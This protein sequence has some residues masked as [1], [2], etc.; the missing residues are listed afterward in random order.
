M[1]EDAGSARPA[2]TRK[3][4]AIMFTDIVGFS[5]Q[6]GADEARMLRLLDLHNQI[7]Q[8]AVTEH[9][10][11]VIKTV[12]DAFLVD[13]P[14]VVH[15]VQC[16][17]HIQAQFRT[18]NADKEPNEQIHVRIGIHLGDIVQRDG[19]VFGDGVNVA[20][21]LQELA[22]P[23]SVCISHMV[24]REVEKK[25]ALGTV[26]SLGRPKLKNI[27]QREPVYALL[28]EKPTGLRQALRVQQFKLSRRVGTAHLARAVLVIV[29]LLIGGGIVTLLYPSLPTF[30]TRPSSLVPQEAPPALPLPDKPSIVVLPFVNLSGDPGQ[31]YFSDGMTEDLITDLS[32]LS[33]LFVIARNSAFTY[34]GKA[35][36]VQEVS[37]DL[38][39]QY[40]LEGSV[41]K[42]DNQVRITAQLVDAT[43]SHHLWAERYDGSPTEIFALQDEV[44]RKI[45]TVLKVKLTKEEQERLKYAPTAN[46][47][48]YDYYLRGLQSFWHLTK[49]AQA[50]ARRMWEKAVELDPRYAAAYAALGWTYYTEWTWQWS[51]D[52]QTLEGALALA[53]QALALD[54]SLPEAHRLL[55]H[56]YLWEKQHDRATAEVEQAI[57]LLPNGARGYADLGFILGFA[58]RPEEA[59]RLEETALRLDPCN[60][61][62]YLWILGG[63]Y[64][65]TGRYEEAISAQKRAL[66]LNPNFLG[67]HLSLAGIYSELGRDREAQAEVTEVLK[68]SPEFSL[69]QARQ[70]TPFKDPAVLE[71]SLDALRKAGLK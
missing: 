13:F 44:R 3:L 52:P 35:V 15:A 49:A 14:S 41:R 46:L 68:I 18:H 22:A 53:Q 11:T 23:D 16:A 56:V 65:L 57:A 69:E 20:S 63:A 60:P 38:G 48:A 2:E 1:P 17:Q 29:G 71:R 5:R 33:G 40:V 8:Q 7:I 9:H 47:E 27:A 64:R 10:G 6:M 28:P 61:T 36:K 26:I 62:F 39:V 32:K 43:T 4:A 55:G 31:E 58:G 45:V 66:I 70:R 24:Y 54:G 25:L 34:K 50:E 59:I 12:G 21:R 42:V 51:E 67:P 37:K 30:I 19:D